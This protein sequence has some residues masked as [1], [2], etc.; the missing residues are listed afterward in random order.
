MPE[1]NF[2]DQF[3]ARKAIFAGSGTAPVAATSIQY[4]K[5]G[6]IYV[7]ERFGGIKIYDVVDERESGGTVKLVLADKIN[8]IKTIPN[9]NDQGEI[10]AA[11][12]DRQLTGIVVNFIDGQPVI[13]ASNSDPRSPSNEDSNLDTNSGIISKLYVDESGEWQ[14]VDLVRGLPRSEENHA[15]NGITLVE[16]D[17]QRFLYVAVGGSTNAGAP[18]DFFGDT[19]EYVYSGS[20]LKIDLGML[21]SM[22]VQEN[23]EDAAHP[24]VYDLPTLNDPT[25]PDTDGEDSSAAALYDVFG[26]NDGRNMAVLEDGGPVTI[27]ATGFRNAYDLVVTGDGLLYATD[28]GAN[29]NLGGVPTLEDGIYSNDPVDE[30]GSLPNVDHLHLVEAGGYYGHPIPLLASGA[31]AGLPLISDPTTEP[32]FGELQN[33][34]PEDFTDEGLLGS[35]AL[36]PIRGEFVNPLS[37]QTGILAPGVAPDGALYGWGPGNSTNGIAEY[38]ATVLDGTL[39]GALVTASFDGQI[40]LLERSADGQSIVA[41]QEVLLTDFSDSNASTKVPLDV[42]VMPDSAGSLAGTI[43]VAQISGGNGNQIVFLTPDGNGVAVDDGDIDDDGIADVLDPFQVDPFNGTASVVE[44]GQTYL[45]PLNAGI[46]GD[47]DLFNATNDPSEASSGLTGAMVD[48]VTDYKGTAP[49]ENLVSTENTIYGGAFGAFAIGSVEGGGVTAGTAAGGANSQDDA[50]QFGFTMAADVVEVDVVGEIANPFR[51]DNNSDPQGRESLG[52]QLGAGDQANYFKIV[53][54]AAEIDG[55]RGGLQVLLEENDAVVYSEFV[56]IP[57]IINLPARADNAVSLI[58]TVDR[59]ALTITPRANFVDNTGTAQSWVGTPVNVDPDGSIAAVIAG[60]YAIGD[61]FGVVDPNGI[62]SGLAAGVIATSVSGTLFDALVDE[63]RIEARDA[64]GVAFAGIE[65][66]DD[67][68][69]D[70]VGDAVVRITAAADDVQTSV[71]T[72]DS[73]TVEN[74]G[75]KRVA[76]VYFDVSKALYGDVVV[77]PFGLAGDTAAKELSIDSAGGTGATVPP[78]P[79][80]G[81]GGE[82]G[83]DGFLLT[84]D[85]AVD[86]GFESGE[87]VGFAVDM[88]ANSI[89]GFAKTEL[90]GAAVP[91]WDVGG[92]SGA[93]LL[94]SEVTVLFTDGTRAR[95][96]LIGDDSQAGA[97]AQVSQTAPS[98]P[99][100][101]IVDGVTEGAAGTYGASGVPQVIVNGPAGATARVILTK[102]TLQP[103]DGTIADTVAARLAGAVF[104]ANNAAEF[105]TVDVVLT[106]EDHDIS[107]LFEYRNDPNGVDLPTFKTLPLGFVAAVVDPATG[108]PQS[109][110]TDPIYVSSDGA[111]VSTLTDFA[112]IDAAADVVVQPLENGATLD[113]ST[114]DFS[115]F[116]IEARSDLA[117]TSLLQ[118]VAFELDGPLN[119]QYVADGPPYALFGESAGDFVG[120]ELLPGQYT[121][122]ATPFDEDGGSGFSSAP[123]SIDFTVTRGR[124]TLLH[125]VNAGGDAVAGFTGTPDGAAIDFEA[126]DGSHLAAGG[127]LIFSNDALGGAGSLVGSERFDPA[128]G[129]EMAWS[130]AVAPGTE[131]VV[132]LYFAEIYAPFDQPGERVFDVTLEGETVL[133]DFDILTEAGFGELVT[134]SFTATA[135][136]DGF[137]DVGFLHELADNPKLNAIAVYEAD[138]GSPNTA[139]TATDDAATTVQGTPLSIDVLANDT[140]ADGD[141]LAIAGTTAA[142]GG[143]VTVLEDGTLTYAPTSG[144]VGTDSFEYTVSDGRGGSATAT[145]T[146]EVTAGPARATLLHAVNAG[147]DAVAGFTGT[148]DGAAIDFEADDGSHLAAGGNLI[149]SN[150]ALGGAGSLVGSERFDPAW[151]DEMAWSFAVA[152]GTEVVV[153]LY[154]A[155][156]YAPFDQPGERVFD[157]TLEG[158]TV[159]DDF[160]ILT[161]AGFGE[162]VTES[163]TATADADGFVD[164]GFLHELADNPKLNA[165]AVYEADA[166]VV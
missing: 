101:L 132:D 47:S 10:E 156:I 65:P 60:T 133:D 59:Q 150:D 39:T 158:E 84:F 160:D 67:Y 3:T 80:F 97:H 102:G 50:A 32:D 43:V 69:A 33:V 163:F 136:A 53:I 66:V 15:N 165:I 105:Q 72:S 11:V 99:V 124:A 42:F 128:W 28:N 83:Y 161:E 76:A 153:D 116:S 78:T 31:A 77:D 24:F 114:F 68:V 94:N 85:P 107:D 113:L 135:D 119:Q 81:A 74:I 21:E 134:E 86:D 164:V 100:T 58:L 137:V 148:P 96:E 151:G 145:V 37:T 141:D 162:L 57:E 44:A 27:H 130:F 147:G 5:D 26:G 131:V 23:L 129:D 55:V 127:N 111:A 29:A 73:F 144:F 82:A 56:S 7:A 140:D 122:T 109:A 64:A 38:T 8:I 36:D 166:L 152:P 87:S 91:T 98:D 121:L 118:S 123:L 143:A 112:L 41:A 71:F 12:F 79:Y 52:I 30:S 138:P 22:P 88:D 62:P 125:A 75:D 20:I 159:L 35:F 103:V 63:F 34:L 89:R 4:G 1:Q 142:A 106:G 18:S 17:D 16:E 13:Y 2:Q 9:H 110:V 40:T 61:T 45:V 95:G 92:V 46:P 157:V 139:P 70:A 51:A 126:D 104:Q 90:N 120:A 115:S 93:E 155:E 6:R 149:F 108:L 49:G 54:T 14:K 117:E 19:P 48:G 25:R 146:V 154:F